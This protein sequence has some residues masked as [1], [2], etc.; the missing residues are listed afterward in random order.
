MLDSIG[1]PP[2]STAVAIMLTIWCVL[3]VLGSLPAL[4]L[5]GMAFEGGH[6]LDAYLTLVA[7]WIYPPLV[8]L[9]FFF[10]RSRPVLV[11]LPFLSGLVLLINQVAWDLGGRVVFSPPQ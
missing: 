6:T 11:C 2:Q 3:L 9:A 5:T 1:P 10:R 7:V 8:G 4:M